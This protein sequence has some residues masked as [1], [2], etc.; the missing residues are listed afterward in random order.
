[1]DEAQIWQDMGGETGCRKMVAAFYRRVRTDDILG[2]MYPADDWEG[3]ED[4]LALFL[5]MRIG[6][7]TRY[8][9]Q[10]GHPRLR[11]RHMPF[12]IGSAARD[13]WMELMTAAMCEA[14]IPESAAAPLEK[15][16]AEIAD[17]MRN[18]PY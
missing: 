2:P 5:A 8:I 7:D 15:F 10:R 1:M 16:F 6:G 18:R 12:A 17:F 14:E 9:A 4:R 13:R 3:A 11:G